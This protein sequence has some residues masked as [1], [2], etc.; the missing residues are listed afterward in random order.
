MHEILR[1]PITSVVL[2]ALIAV[3]GIHVA[4]SQFENARVDMTADNLYSLS[5]GTE[6]ILE[7]MHSEGIKPIELKLYFSETTGKTLPRFIKDFVTYERYLRALLQEYAVA[8]KGK[9]EVSYFDPLPDSDEAQDAQDF[10]LE[11]K[12]INQHGDLF[13]FGLVFETQ[14]GSR[15]VIEFLWPSLQESVE[16]EISKKLSGLIWPQRQRVGVLSGLEVLGSG[17]NPYTAQILA[18][19]GKSPGE[20][21]IAM[22]LLQETYEVREIA[23]DIDQISRDDF[24]LVVV[25][26]PKNLGSRALWALDEWIVRGGNALIF[27]DPYSID[28]QPPQ[29]PQNPLQ[30]YQYEPSSNLSELFGAWGLERP[31]GLIAADREIAIRRPV[32]RGGIPERVVIDLAIDAASAG[33]TLETGHPVLQGLMDLRFF[34]AGTLRPRAE[35][36]EGVELQPLITTTASGN[37]L[38][39]KAGFPTGDELTFLDLGQPNKLADALQPGT[40]P[41]ALAYLVQGKLPPLYPAG[42]SLPAEAPQPPPGLPPG[43]ELPEPEGGERIEKDAVPEEERASSTVMVFSDVDFLSDQLAFQNSIFGAVAVNDN[44]KILLNAVDY[45]FGSEDLMNVRAKRTINRP[46]T[47]FDQIEAEAD[48]LSLEREQTLRADI[49]RFEEELR[50]KTSNSGNV[51]LLQKQLQDEVEQL[52]ERI[53]QSNRELREIRQEKRG[54]LEAEEA[55]VRFAAIGLMPTLILMLGLGLFVRRRSRDLNARRQS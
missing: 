9:V 10:G 11:G 32:A 30:A 34:T 26:H 18:A 36:P 3:F 27:V 5:G 15:D 53:N 13:F 12:P 35:V 37:T 23:S 24:D 49:Q 43:L 40:E 4:T 55:K 42:T 8:S 19:Q 25:L 20:A 38:A 33:E 29:N 22:Q 46:F 47:L 41:V 51:A 6:S 54:A 52:N 50:D 45:L 39:I 2:V 7:K 17:A 31:E 48:E 28:D 1:S 21:W 44:H 14:T 16:Y